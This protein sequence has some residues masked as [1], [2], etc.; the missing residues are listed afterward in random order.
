VSAIEAYELTAAEALRAI[1]RRELGVAELVQSLLDRIERVEPAIQAWELIDRDGVLATARTCDASFDRLAHKSLFGIPFGLKDIYDTRGMT[2]S[3]GFPPWA[4]RVPDR[5]AATVERL[6]DAGAIV[7]GKTVTTQFAF[8]DPPK[9]CNPWNSNRTPG[10]SSSGSAAAVA[11]RM[12]PVALGSQTAGSI[13]RPAAYCGVLGLKPTYGLISRFG[14][15]PL[16]WSLDHPG[17]IARSV[18]DLAL[19]LTVLAGPDPRDP[20]TAQARVGDYLAATRQP[21]PAPVCGVIED[22]FDASEPAVR[23][24]VQGAIGSLERA[25]ARLRAVRLTTGLQLVA[26]AQQTTMQ[27]EAAEVHSALHQEMAEQYA[28]RMRALVETGQLVP[29]TLY[30]R[31]QRIRRRFRAEIAAVLRDVDC[32]LMPTVSNLAP[33]RTTTGDRTFQAPWSLIGLPALTLPAGLAAGLPYGL[34]IVTNAWQETRLLAIA[35]WVENLLP[36]VPSAL[37]AEK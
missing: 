20:A 29:A 8:A 1:R 12:V 22:F 4:N 3:A 13:L 9:T 19:A 7:L 23:E 16:A 24:G 36:R 27:V 31:A 6:R 10:G 26:D 14:I 21:S 33:D 28:P 37:P 34:Q 18:E 2:T 17:P 15:F 25:G 5:D 35:Q 30:L 11:A 32:L